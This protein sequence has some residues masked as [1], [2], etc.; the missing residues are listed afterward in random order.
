M[1]FFTKTTT[2]TVSSN[3]QHLMYNESTIEQTGS[4]GNTSNFHLNLDQDTNYHDS[5]S[6][7]VLSPTR[8]MPGYLKL[9]QDASFHVFFN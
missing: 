7:A 8:K 5:I 6:M 4:K 2:H 9:D 1:Q 3:Q